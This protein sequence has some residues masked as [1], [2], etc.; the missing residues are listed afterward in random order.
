MRLTNAARVSQRRGRAAYGW[1]ITLAGSGLPKLPGFNKKDSRD[2]PKWFQRQARKRLSRAQIK[3]IDGERRR[4]E[5][6]LLSVDES[7][8]E[9]SR[10][11]T[12][13]ALRVLRWYGSPAVS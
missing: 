1:K 3:S 7:V 6:Q 11:N 9:P 4:Q 12:L 13:R 2:K 5:E 8:G 10:W